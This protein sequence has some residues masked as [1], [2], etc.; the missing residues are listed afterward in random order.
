MWERIFTLLRKE[1]RSVLRDPRM[2]MVILGIPIIQTLIFGYA[3]TLDVRHVP[4]VIID[5]DNTVASR[6]LIQRFIGSAYFDAIARTK[7]FDGVTGKITIDA[8]RNA[9][10]SAVVLKVVDGKAK[11]ETSIAP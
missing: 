1:F 7:D 3:V 6:A 5:R 11:F 2:R 9:E 8:Q 10:K 4:L